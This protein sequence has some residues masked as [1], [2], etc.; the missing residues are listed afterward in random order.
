MWRS[1]LSAT[2]CCTLSRTIFNLPDLLRS[3][4]DPPRPVRPCDASAAVATILRSSPAGAELLFIVR[5]QR[6]DDPWSG[7]V[8]FPGG[9]REPADES[10]LHTAVRETEEE[11]SL[12]LAPA[13]CV[14]Q[15]DVVAAA[16]SGAR[17]AQFVFPLEDEAAVATTSA[18]VSATLWVPLAQLARFEGAGT[19]TYV[20]E[21]RAVELP[22]L[23][24]GPHV[25]WG[26]TYRMVL[27]LLRAVGL[28]APFLALLAGLHGLA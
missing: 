26:L 22:C 2:D 23:Q 20:R 15:L 8:A 6:A 14:A 28:P 27:Q 12:R 21:G 3:L 4:R 17:V 18:E 7:H 13:A 24:L 16:V 9:K 1:A 19:F 10:L 5:A 25:L 11:V